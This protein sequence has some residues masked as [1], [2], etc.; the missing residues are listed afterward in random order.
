M[1][2]SLNER[3]AR[4]WQL[5]LLFVLWHVAT[6]P[7]LIPPLVFENDQQAA[8]FFGEPL[9]VFGRIWALSLIHI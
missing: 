1:M 5:V 7:G 4:F 8:F 2:P 9:K 6:K 3:N